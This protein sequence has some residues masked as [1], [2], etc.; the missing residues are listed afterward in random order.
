MPRRR[1]GAAGAGNPA[2]GV[3]REDQA[4]GLR[5]LSGSRHG[6]SASRYVSYSPHDIRWQFRGSN[7]LAQQKQ[8]TESIGLPKLR[9]RARLIPEMRSLGRLRQSGDP[10]NNATIINQALTTK[11]RGTLRNRLVSI[12]SE[13]FSTTGR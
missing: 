3:A 1:G 13:H 7:W 5:T 11:F 9:G 10:S 6:S 8:S 2:T 4:I 12:L